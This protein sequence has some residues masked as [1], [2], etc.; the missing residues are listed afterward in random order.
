MVAEA[1]ARGATLPLAEQALA[2]Y[3]EALE[4]G[5]GTRD[6]AWLPAY[7]PNRG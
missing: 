1:N 3:A 7:W 4:Q 5:W 6:G 2:V